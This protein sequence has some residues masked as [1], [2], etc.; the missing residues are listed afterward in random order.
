MIVR[1]FYNHQAFPNTWMV[2]VSNQDVATTQS[3]GRVVALFDDQQALVGYNLLHATPLPKNGYQDM[4]DALL[5]TLNAMLQEAGVAALEH[6]A[7]PYLVVGH[8]DT[9]EPHPD[10]T[11][12]HVCKVN[13]GN[14][15]VQ[16]VCGAANVAE[17]QRVVI[18][19]EQAVLPNGTLILGGKLRGVQ[20]DGMLCS[21]YELGLIQEK[22]KGILVLDERAEIGTPFMGGGEY[23]VE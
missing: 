1:V 3:H 17:G 12:M 21:A 6:D 8:V 18:A 14:K 16:I 2:R 7:T 19:L 4:S 10:S 9:C 11:H 23:R 15:Q 22:K 20:S 5:T 13:V